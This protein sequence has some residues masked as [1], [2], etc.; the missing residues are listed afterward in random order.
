MMRLTSPPGALALLLLGSLPGC[1][2]APKAD[3]SQ[4]FVLTPMSSEQVSGSAS[5]VEVR[6][7][8]GPVGLPEYLRR[9]HMV[10]RIGPN[11]ISFSEYD[12]WAQPLDAS[13][14]KVLGENLSQLL[15]VVEMVDHPWFSTVK[16]DY[17]VEVEVNQ[18]ER[19]TM[20]AAHLSCTWVVRDGATGDRIEDGEF[21]RIEPV[22]SSGTGASVAAQSRLLGELGRE[23]ARE[24]ASVARAAGS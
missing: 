20:G 3:P 4:F 8:L 19:D 21:N 11:E 10:T 2:L 9:P 13:F 14:V 16:L 17:T 23:I 6:L 15:G 5:E 24:I 18:F 7:G 22:D 12:R 1:S